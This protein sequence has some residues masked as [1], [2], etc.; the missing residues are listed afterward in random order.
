M[1]FWSDNSLEPKRQFKFKVQ[2]GNAL[3]N[4]IQ[5][6]YYMAQAA[7][8]PTYKV[9]DTGK[10]EFL[11]KTYYYPGKVTWEPVKIMFVDA[12]SNDLQAGTQKSVYNYL[13]NAGWISPE[14]AGAS[15]GNF[16]T[17][18][19]SKAVIPLVTVTSLNSAGVSIDTFTLNNAFITSHTAN[20]LSY[21]EESI[22]TLELTLRYDWASLA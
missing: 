10:V 13:T 18:G 22:L 2:F 15:N 21:T 6:P 11:D 9:S 20:R 5:I 12:V 7:D 16:A 3:N 14:L 4:P 1:A 8:R 19:K 17:I